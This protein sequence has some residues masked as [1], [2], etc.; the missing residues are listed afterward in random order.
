MFCIKSRHDITFEGGVCLAVEE[1]AG[2]LPLIVVL[3]TLL[4]GEVSGEGSCRGEPLS[5]SY[6]FVGEG[7]C[8]YLLM[9]EITPCFGFAL[10]VYR[11]SGVG[12]KDK[13]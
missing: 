9:R 12:L 1:I 3:L 2:A 11:G 7:L 4:I 8:A 10:A 13:T 6:L 5:A